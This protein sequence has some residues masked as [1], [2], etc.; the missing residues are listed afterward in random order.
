MAGSH[1]QTIAFDAAE[2]HVSATFGKRDAADGLSVGRK[3]H[4]AVEIGRAHPPAAPQ[5]PLAITAHTVG[6]A[7]ASVDQHTPVGKLPTAVLNVVDKD[8]AVWNAAA[9]DNVK[10]LFVRVEA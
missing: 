2:A 8:F 6:G 5:V 1:E 4:H 10:Q 3:Y 7:C 9:F